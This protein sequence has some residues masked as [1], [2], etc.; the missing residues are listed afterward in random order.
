V[1]IIVGMV[2]AAASSIFVEV[3]AAGQKL[4]FEQ[5]PTSLGFGTG[6]WRWAAVVLLVGACL[7]A[8]AQLMPGHT[9]KGP[10]TGFHF[11][12]PLGLVP[13]VLVASL[14]TLVFGFAL[15]PEA[16]LIVLGPAVGAILA[17]PR[18]SSAVL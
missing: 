9:G 13:S 2:A 10:L 6:R 3:V 8:L 12:D 5:V 15:G 14:A 17:R 18:C 11:D 16:P 4:L 7:V 1:A